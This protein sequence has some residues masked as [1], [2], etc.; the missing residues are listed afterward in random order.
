MLADA[1]TARFITAMAGPIRKP[2]PGARSPLIGHWQLLATAC[3][4]RRARHRRLSRRVGP[5]EPPG[6]PG[7]EIAWSIARRPR[8]GYAQE[9]ARAAIDWAFASFPLERI[10]SLIHPDNLASQRVATRLGER[11]TGEQFAPFHDPCDIWEMRREDWPAVRSHHNP[12]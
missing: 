2:R 9:A 12:G 7:C 11:P 8:K 5:L 3:C 10:I 4:R 6:Y 1:Q